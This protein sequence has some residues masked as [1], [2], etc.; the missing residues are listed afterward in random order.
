MSDL[1]MSN[2]FFLCYG[3]KNGTTEIG[4][5][6]DLARFAPSYQAHGVGV[7]TGATS[8]VQYSYADGSSKTIRFMGMTYPNGRNV[9]FDYGI[10]GS[11]S[12]CGM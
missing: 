9:V 3:V 12:N 10:T 8:Q 11:M 4:L 5:H 6:R 2:D 7:N 1:A